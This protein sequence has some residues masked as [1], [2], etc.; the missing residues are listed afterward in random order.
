M[1]KHT[2]SLHLVMAVK[3]KALFV[4]GYPGTNGLL[5]LKWLSFDMTTAA[6][7]TPPTGQMPASTFWGAAKFMPWSEV[8]E[9]LDCIVDNPSGS[10][11]HAVTAW[12]CSKISFLFRIGFR[13]G[14]EEGG[15]EAVTAFF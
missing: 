4:H 12:L 11:S 1:A 8:M 7:S 5:E 6:L 3:Q 13:D 10:S 9:K 14:E 2:E 15:D